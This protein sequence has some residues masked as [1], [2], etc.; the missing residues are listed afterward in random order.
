M[1]TRK[2][3]RPGASHRPKLYLAYPA[4]ESAR[5]DVD[6]AL[7]LLMGNQPFTPGERVRMLSEFA[8][9]RADAEKLKQAAR[10]SRPLGLPPASGDDVP[11]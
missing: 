10:Q 6:E 4:V 2:P 9:V 5:N 3:A 11:A 8:R 7:G 1:D